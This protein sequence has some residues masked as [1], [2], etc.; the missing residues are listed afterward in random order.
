[1]RPILTLLKKLFPNAN[2]SQT[3][4]LRKNSALFANLELVRLYSNIHK[5]Q[6]SPRH[7]L[8]GREKEKSHSRSLSGDI[9]NEK[10]QEI[11]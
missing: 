10:Q 2:V 7:P 5:K 1:M 8:A 6:P 9:E 11:V 4:S 3:A